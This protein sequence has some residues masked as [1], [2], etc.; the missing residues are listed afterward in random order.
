MAGDPSTMNAIRFCT[1]TAQSSHSPSSPTYPTLSNLLETLAHPTSIF[2]S[3]S[4]KLPRLLHDN[5]P[6]PQYT[7]NLMRQSLLRAPVRY[8]Q[9]LVSM[10]HE[11]ESTQILIHLMRP[12][13]NTVSDIARSNDETEV[14]YVDDSATHLDPHLFQLLCLIL[15]L[16]KI[17][18]IDDNFQGRNIYYNNRA[19]DI[20][21]IPLKLLDL[22]ICDAL[23]ASIFHVTELLGS[24][25]DL[26]KSAVDLEICSN[27]VELMRIILSISFSRFSDLQSKVATVV[28]NV[29]ERTEVMSKINQIMKGTKPIQP[30][31]P[32]LLQT[33]ASICK[34]LDC[35]EFNDNPRK[36]F[37]NFV[38]L[39]DDAE[40]N[41]K[42]DSREDSA[43]EIALRMSHSIAQCLE[44]LFELHPEIVVS[45]LLQEN[46]QDHAVTSTGT[47]SDLIAEI[48]TSK[49]VR[50]FYTKSIP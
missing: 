42:D 39:L 8:A 20:S 17:E 48:L 13:I 40:G 46:A 14:D 5:A 7:I 9:Q 21:L 47:L 37:G 49:Q 30:T 43:M 18:Y 15:E 29:A 16:S 4:A 41:L 50:T 12:P 1:S 2:A 27:V 3:I 11:N 24:S 22:G 33:L 10:W 19:H 28:G 25:T 31:L 23:A 44:L 6:L 34:A 45:K 36:S 26:G 32:L 38:P 35:E